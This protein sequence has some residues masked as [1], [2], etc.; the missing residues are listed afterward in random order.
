[1]LYNL[2]K[3]ELAMDTFASQATL[4]I[5]HSDDDGIDCAIGY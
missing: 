3:E 2:I 5:G 4:H 1:V